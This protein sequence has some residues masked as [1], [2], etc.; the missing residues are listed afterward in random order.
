MAARFAWVTAPGNYGGNWCSPAPLYRQ[1]SA[2]T[3][4]SARVV[5]M[6]SFEFVTAS[7]GAC[8]PGGGPL[9]TDRE[10]RR[11]DQWMGDPAS[12]FADGGD[13][14]FDGDYHK[15]RW[16]A[17]GVIE[18]DC[19]LCHQP[20][21]DFKSREA[22]LNS[23]NFRWA[24]TAAAGFGNVIGR[25]VSNESPRVVYDLS[26]FDADGHVLVKSVPSPRNETCLTCHAKP[27]WKKRGASFSSRT[28][29]HV[30]AGLRCVDC[31]PAGSRAADGRVRGREIHQIGKG[32]DP[33][34]W[35]RNDLDD[36]VRS[37]RD[38]HI[39]GWRNAPRAP[40]AWLPPLHLEKLS[41]QAC[42]IPNRAIKSAAVQASDVFNAAPYVTPPGKRIW[43]FYDQNR[44]AWNHYGELATFGHS[45]KPSDYSLPTLFRYKGLIYPGNR[46]HSMWVGYEEDGMPGLNMLFMRDYYAMWR[47]HRESG[48]TNYAQLVAIRD[49][50]G[51]GAPEINR[52]EEIDAVLAATHEHLEKTGF[53][54]RGRRLVWV[55]DARAY[56]SSTESRALPRELHEAT[57]YASVHKYSH[58]VAPARAALGTGGCTDCHASPSPFFDRPVLK[59]VFAAEDGRPLWAPNREL[60]G[61]S[62][63]AARIGAF[64]EQRLKPVLYALAGLLAGMWALV[65]L[66]DAAVR[67]ALLPKRFASVCLWAGLAGLVAAGLVASRDP[68]MGEYMLARRF[69]LDASHFWIAIGILLAAFM[70]CARL[71][72]VGMARGA[73]RA[74]GW[75]AL[76]VTCACGGLMLLKPGGFMAAATRLSYTGFDIGL[77]VSAG[78]A[79][80]ALLVASPK[81]SGAQREG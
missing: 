63:S 50:D 8:H 20:S 60:L 31:H 40:H 30:A 48:G 71:P 70:A 64:R 45:D 46:V 58:D 34:G 5:D 51:D 69:T 36:T 18:A 59:T 49:D 35:V 68:G 27:G 81:V 62:A 32:D 2:K 13:N 19:L 1:L 23:L 72:R 78:F 56:Y 44:Q 79:I 15:A 10:G 29:V 25:V 52:P 43:T 24:A 38:C 57:P 80:S 26:K 61:V 55:C 14:R 66:R 9:E 54:L 47:G 28:D 33:A 76:A 41:C 65:C 67:H 39:D 11:Y 37:C 53:P 4:A 16:G 22:Q 7:C 75:V 42:H 74:A 21:Y 12:G 17:S 77:A 73:M 6:T 3:N